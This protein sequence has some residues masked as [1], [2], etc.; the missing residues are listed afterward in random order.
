MGSSPG[1]LNPPPPSSRD[2]GQIKGCRCL[3]LC[4]C[5]CVCMVEV[6]EEWIENYTAE[7]Y[8]W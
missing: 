6:D 3:C 7:N 5:V 1:L 2:E 8:S 4:E